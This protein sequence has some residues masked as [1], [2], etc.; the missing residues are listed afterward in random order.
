MRRKTLKRQRK[1]RGGNAE[2]QDDVR[3]GLDALVIYYLWEI[4]TKNENDNEERDFLKYGEYE[5]LVEAYYEYGQDRDAKIGFDR[6]T[7]I[8]IALLFKI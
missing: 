2:D 4:K 8:A 1:Q 3:K 6:P 7:M 5:R